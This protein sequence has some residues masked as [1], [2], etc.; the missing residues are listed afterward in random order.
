MQRQVP[1]AITTSNKTV[2]GHEQLENCYAEQTQGGKYGFTIKGVAGLAKHTVLPYSTGVKAL[3]QAL[4]RGF[5]ITSDTLYEITSSGTY[6][7]RGTVQLVGTRVIA[8]DNGF[9]LVMVDG[10]KGYSFDFT[11][12]VLAEI[13]D[14]AFY[15]AASVTTQDGYFIFERTG[16]RQFFITGIFAVTFDPLDIASANGQPDN[17]VRVLS[18]HRELIIFCED[19]IEFWYNSGA[20]DFPFQR[21]EGSFIER[22]L[23]ARYSATKLDDVVYFVGNDRN[24]Y[25]LAGYQTREISTTPVADDLQGVNIDNCYGFAYTQGEDKFYLLTIPSRNRTW[26]YNIQTGSWFIRSSNQFGRYLANNIMRFDNKNLV[27]D[28]QAGMVYEQTTAALNDDGEPILKRF[29]LPTI[30]IGRSQRSLFS[31]ELDMLTGVGQTNGDS[32]DPKAAL[33]VSKDD[34]STWSSSMLARIGKKG[35]RL[36][37]TK[38]NRLGNARQFLLE[39]TV[40]A[41]IELDVGGAWV[42]IS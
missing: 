22:G 18:D 5:A 40:T 33:R 31:F 12:N 41:D 24:V 29:V 4:G 38:W 9:Q 17:I 20:A 7:N 19:T 11:T 8:E 6:I 27:G 37:R 15:P 2:A 13:T 14:P 3:H 42:E 32:S 16:T 26:V 34:G 30:N 36:T 39:V 25:M 1:L 23:G 35:E 28:F 10:I 21:S